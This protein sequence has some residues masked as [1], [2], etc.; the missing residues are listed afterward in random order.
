VEAFHT[1]A[2]VVDCNDFCSCEDRAACDSVC[3]NKAD[4]FFERYL[5]IGGF[6]L[7]STPRVA[8]LETPAL[9]SVVPLIGHKYRRKSALNEPV[10]AV[11]LYEL[12]HMG[13]GQPHVRTRAEFAAR[14]RVP[15]TATVVASGVD[16]DIKLEAW[17]AFADRELIMSTQRDLGIALVTVP[18][19]SLFLNVP[20]PDNLHRIKRIVLGWAELMAAG[21][22][23]ALHLNARTDQDYARWMRFV[24]ECSEVEIV[25]F[26]F[27]T[28]AGAPSRIDWHVDR[29]RRIADVAGRPLTLVVRGG[30][31]VLRRL[32]RHF[33]QIILIETD[34][35][36]RTLKRRR[37]EFTES[38][39]LRW[40]RISTPK[41]API[42]DLLIHNIVTK[43]TAL[44]L[45]DFA[46]TAQSERSSRNARRSVQHADGQ[47]AAPATAMEFV[48]QR[49]WA[50][51]LRRPGR[52]LLT[53]IMLSRS[54]AQ[55]I[56]QH[57]IINP[58]DWDAEH[59][60]GEL[61]AFTCSRS[62]FAR[63]LEAVMHPLAHRGPEALANELNEIL[64]R[65]G[66]RLETTGEASGYPIYTL[67][68]L[69]RGVAGAPKKLIFASTGPKP[70]LSFADAVN[71]DVVIL[72]G[73]EHCLI[74]DR[75]IRSDGLLWSE[76]V[77]WWGELHP[78]ESDPAKS[79]GLRLPASLSS[80]S[81]AEQAVFDTYFRRYRP[82][83]QS[84]LPALIPQ[85]YLHY[86]PA[87]VRTLKHRSSFPR[88]RMDFL[89]LLP[90]RARVVIEVD[91]QH[92]FTR[93]D[94]PSLA[95]YAEMVS[96]DR[97]LR[98]AGYEI[99]RFGA[100]E[101]VD[102]GAQALIERFFD[103]LFQLHRVGSA[104]TSET[105][106]DRSETSR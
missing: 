29:L 49:W 81:L 22:P 84:A 13:S 76:L 24:Q 74:F 23:A 16:R 65:D 11:P 96:A 38:G 63:P 95:A 54:L 34:A 102:A 55:Q 37:A 48:V 17:W 86:D 42:D 61:S 62:R 46:P 28:G 69:H 15:E 33:G 57:M 67:S 85:V 43:R 32:R 51:L 80:S 4:Q 98:L 35:F 73:A 90:N 79:L 3:R 45:S 94:K 27:R 18:N 8:A 19:F 31:Q 78:E 68:R 93:N 40:P 97:D 41:G 104:A 89:L 47:T 39:R 66:Y 7:E 10:V 1:D 58:T 5:E 9:P 71:N 72:A 99:F 87:V 100:N 30:A 6:E 105:P 36:A 103:R 50:E 75:S 2:G 82:M 52:S 44:Q 77:S 88:Q 106:L 20:R 21:I 60:F 64:R 92:H 14:F 83:L 70:E 56:V 25:A 12:F 53:F 26:E 59:L 101:L 91:G